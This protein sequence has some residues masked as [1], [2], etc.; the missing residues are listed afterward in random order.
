MAKNELED[1]MEIKILLSLIF[2]LL[3]YGCNSSNNDNQNIDIKNNTMIT[4]L[5]DTK[6]SYTTLVTKNNLVLMGGDEGFNIINSNQNNRNNSFKIPT[7]KSKE[8]L[9]RSNNAKDVKIYSLVEQKDGKI[10]IGGNFGYIN[11]YKTDSLVRLNSDG[12]IDST[13]EAMNTFNGEIYTIAILDDDSILIGG[14]FKNIKNQEYSGL[15]KLTKEGKIDTLFHNSLI[16]FDMS[17]VNDIKIID[18]SIYLGGSFVKL[19]NDR[20]QASCPN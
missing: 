13:F 6:N 12:S 20:C 7:F 2:A 4:E 9:N 10:I 17:V 14:Y 1:N 15:V 5:R 19:T 11:E 8:N 3:I 16:E 18:N